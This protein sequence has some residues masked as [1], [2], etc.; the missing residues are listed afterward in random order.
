MPTSYEVL[1]TA[2]LDRQPR[3]SQFSD[4]SGRNVLLAREK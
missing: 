1:A 3:R 2:I 4:I